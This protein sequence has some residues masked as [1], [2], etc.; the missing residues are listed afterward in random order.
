MIVEGVVL[1]G[2]IVD[3]LFRGV[4]FEVGGKYVEYYIL[5][6]WCLFLL[7]TLFLIAYF[8][9][10]VAATIVLI[11]VD[12]LVGG[13]MLEGDCIICWVFVF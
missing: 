10:F 1:G 11:I 7:N 6:V 4:Y 5:F 13:F 8:F 3:G 2:F 9:G 12:V